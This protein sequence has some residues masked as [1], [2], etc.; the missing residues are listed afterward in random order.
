MPVSR[1][2]VSRPAAPPAASGSAP[3]AAPRGA[4]RR[5]V[6]CGAALVSA[7]AVG[8][9][10]TACGEGGSQPAEAVGEPV[11][12]GPAEEVPVGGAQLYRDEKVLVCRPEAGEYRAF[13]AVCPHAGCVLSGI[14]DDVA[15]CS[16]HGSTFE[17]ATGE[18]LRGPAEEPLTPLE[19]EIDAGDGVMVARPQA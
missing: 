10:A 5:T 3:S 11:Q 15:V 14:R 18:V 19:L 8:L 13:S 16:C 7:G 12:L 2:D 1:P 6:L 9:T 4:S 17:P